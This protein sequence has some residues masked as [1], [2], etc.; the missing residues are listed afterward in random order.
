MGDSNT[1]RLK[2]VKRFTLR[3]NKGSL[4]SRLNSDLL[5]FKLWLTV[6]L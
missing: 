4:P 2:R 5:R 3:V 6:M 1:I